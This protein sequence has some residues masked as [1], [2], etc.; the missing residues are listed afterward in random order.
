MGV[1]LALSA[2]DFPFCFLAVKMVGPERVGQWEHAVIDAVR[3]VVQIPFPNLMKKKEDA[4]IE[5]EAREAAAVKTEANAKGPAS[6][7]NIL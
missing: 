1:Y 6:K 4:L 3:S 5:A 7:L 2:L